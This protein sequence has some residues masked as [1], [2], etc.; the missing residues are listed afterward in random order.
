MKLKISLYFS[1]IYLLLLFFTLNLNYI[2]GDDA[3]T[4]LHHAMGRD[5]NFQP[6]YSAY[7]SMFDTLLSLLQTENETF[8]RKFSIVISFSSGLF[9]LILIS[10]LILTKT[11]K[12]KR[13]QTFYILM[14]LPFIV[15]ELLF[16][17]LL[18][19]PSLV[20][21]VFILLSHILLLNY[22]RKDRVVLLMLSLFLFGFGVSFRWINGFY[23]FVL[24]GDF[25]LNEKQINTKLFNLNR[26]V[27]SLK[28]FPFY[29]VSV[30]SFIWISGYSPQGIANTVKTVASYIEGSEV[31][32]LA[33][34]ATSISFLTPAF[35][36][37]LVL[38]IIESIK[39]K[40]FRIL[41]WLGIALLPF[42]VIGF[43]PSLKYLMPILLVVFLISINGFILIKNRALK[44]GVVVLIFIFWFVG[45]QINSNSTWGPGFELKIKNDNLNLTN[46]F[47]PDKSLIIKNFKPVIG[48]GMAMPTLEGPRPVYGFGAVLLYDWKDFV[49]SH[50]KERMAAV[51]FSEENNCR[52]LQ[53]VKHAFI[54]SKLKEIGYT[55]ED[56]YFKKVAEFYEREFVKQDISIIVNVVQQKSMLFD[57]NVMDDFINENSKIIIY[58]SYS[59]IITKISTI[60]KDKFVIKGAYWG[61]LS[62]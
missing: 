52:I 51:R 8:L 19:N 21:M 36:L 39:T 23:L 20:S 22:L 56:E 5:A 62:R 53:D 4:V 48:S 10:Q 58:S 55:T 12:D 6:V 17:S 26:V 2:E 50:N 54:Y 3:N 38:G 35:L 24:F 27:K 11:H 49:S 1:A 15:P 29:I 16:N 46:S 13:R 32:Y 7:H 37:L 44:L 28:I 25:I 59:N 40:S 14:L 41:V 30:I 18:V 57:K 42:F 33:L 43:F 34:I 31:S 9:F 61:V 45:V 47:N 60:Y